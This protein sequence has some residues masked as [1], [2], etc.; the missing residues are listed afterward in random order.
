MRNLIPLLS[1]MLV[2][3][4]LGSLGAAEEQPAPGSNPVISD[5]QQNL[6]RQIGVWLNVN[7]EAINGT[8]P[9]KMSGEGKVRFTTKGGRLYAILLGWPGELAS[10]PAL[11]SG[12][13]PRIESVRLLGHQARLQ[14]V[15]EESGLKVFMPAQKPCDYAFSL[16]IETAKSDKE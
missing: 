3:A 15:Q 2:A 7:G 5:D 16:K 12:K 9:W 6:L 8:R 11:A 1:A 14:F 13:H 4:Q 10:I